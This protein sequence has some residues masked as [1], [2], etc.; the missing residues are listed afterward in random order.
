VYLDGG[1]Q[2]KSVQKCPGGGSIAMIA[3]PELRGA[4]N[5]NPL[6]SYMS[7]RSAMNTLKEIGTTAN[8]GVVHPSNMTSDVLAQFR[9]LAREFELPGL[10]MPIGEFGLPGKAYERAWRKVS[11]FMHGILDDGGTLSVICLFGGRCAG[12]VVARLLIERGVEPENAVMSVA[13]ANELAAVSQSQEL[14]LLNSIR[15]LQTFAA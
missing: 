8:L 6:H 10:W 9:R 2:V 11:P 15:P 1:F 3:F 14:W 7:I 5:Q 4:D 13:N 12:A